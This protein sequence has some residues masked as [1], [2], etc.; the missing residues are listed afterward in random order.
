MALASKN[1]G[2]GLRPDA[3]RL[4]WLPVTVRVAWDL[5]SHG[6][7][8]RPE[9]LRDAREHVLRSLPD[10]VGADDVEQLAS[11]YTLDFLHR[12]R[13][14]RY[15]RPAVDPD[16][17]MPAPRVW[18]D[19]L[20]SASDPIADAVLRLHYGD[21]LSI[22]RV[23][24]SIAV[25]ATLLLAA[26]EGLREATREIGR[27]ADLPIGG[28]TDARLDR[29]LVR[30]ANAPARGCPGPMGLLSEAGR[31]HGDI[32]PRCSRAIR[33]IRHGVLAPSDL[34]PP[35]GRP[36]Y[37]EGHNGLLALLLHPDA[38][39]SQG[40]VAA[41][42]G[43]AATPVGPDSWLIDEGDLLV[44]GPRLAEL[45]ELGTPLRHHLRGAL[46]HGAIRWSKG[47][48][49]GPLPTTALEAARARPWAEIQGMA[50]LPPPRPPPPSS[51]R[52]WIAT[53]VLALAVGL[54]GAL[55]F[56]ALPDERPAAPPLELVRTGVDNALRFDA[57]DGAAVDV[58]VEVDG[59]VE[60]LGDG[61]VAG[62]G[63]WATGEGDYEILLPSPNFLLL[64][65]PAP[66]ADLDAIIARGEA[67]GTG[68]DGIASAVVAAH[69]AV[70]L[71]R[72]AP[73]AATVYSP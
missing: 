18:R 38:R 67:A 41:T 10:G 29:L 58:L 52:W 37:A 15:R 30:I 31:A 28:W 40:V 22:E 50:P 1:A 2:S 65:S 70:V 42:L 61:S 63:R 24:Q 12:V 43:D 33:L 48:A 47:V 36:L 23:E 11:T 66:L 59:K 54:V 17:T 3:L 69:P 55:M 39:R 25:D 46:V 4:A 14:R 60:R 71:R 6:L 64:T 72:P 9:L 68:L 21:G 20:V 45:A 16:A 32:C 7:K 34:F 57:A 44:V 62:K 5:L 56:V 27:L 35:D 26:Q 53:G 19:Q 73:T 13:E 49:L 51:A 8:V